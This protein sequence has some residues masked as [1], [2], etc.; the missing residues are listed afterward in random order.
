MVR[1]NRTFVLAFFYGACLFFNI[2]FHSL[3][4]F[5]PVNVQLDHFFI[6][7]HCAAQFFLTSGD[8]AWSMQRYID[9]Q[10][11]RPRPPS[12]TITDG[13]QRGRGRR[14]DIPLLQRALLCAPALPL[15][16]RCEDD[17]GTIERLSKVITAVQCGCRR[18]R[19]CR[20]QCKSGRGCGHRCGS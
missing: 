3:K 12:R 14:R 19:R 7:E 16:N 4:L 2:L 10:R 15:G 17:V 11:L 9:Q 18:G 13:R 5:L 20:Y 1:M 6:F 8:D